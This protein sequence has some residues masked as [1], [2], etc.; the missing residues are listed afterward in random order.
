MAGPVTYASLKRSLGIAKEVTPGTPVAPTAF[1]P[2]TKFDWN[3]KPTWLKDMGLRQ[4]M[5]NDAFGIQQ[6]VLIGEIDIEGPVFADTLGFLLGNLMGDVTTTGTATAP[7]GTLTASSIIGATSVLS[8]VS[9]PTGTLIQIGSGNGAE[10]VT[11]SGPPVG[12]AS[13]FTIPVP[14]LT[15]PHAGPTPGPADAIT[16]IQATG[17]NLHAF[18]LLNTGS[19]QPTTHT[20]TQYYGPT[21]STGTRQYTSVCFSEV[22]LKWNAETEFLTY[23]A[24]ATAWVSGTAST[25]TATFTAATPL[26]SWR[27]LLGLAGPA[28]GGTQVLTAETGE[29]TFKRALKPYFTAQNSQNPYIIQ[30]GGFSADWKNSFVAADETPLTYMRSNTQPQH[31]F[32]ISN[33][34][35]GANALGLQVD[36]QQAA[37]TEAKPNFGKEAVGFDAAGSAVFNTTN[38]GYSGG[39]S[40]AKVTLTNAIAAGTYI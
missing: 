2:I 20:L 6:G 8:T 28:S 21:A 40:P 9:I 37:F 4:S 14:A 33:G 31:Q 7:T 17:P 35:T 11:T 24:K 26:A 10:I 23:T 18:S 38:A 19:G 16:A 12:T 36:I 25:P 39:L 34:L 3:D 30:R 22:G 15:K 29:Y 1:I 5:G 32:I 13:P 27:G